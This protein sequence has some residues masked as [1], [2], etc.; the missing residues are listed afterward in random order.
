MRTILALVAVASALVF[1]MVPIPTPYNII[2]MAVLVVCVLMLTREKRVIHIVKQYV[3]VPD[4]KELQ[5]RL[6]SAEEKFHEDKTRPVDVD[7]AQE[8]INRLRKR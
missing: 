4:K 2:P 7:K 1:A 3:P 6:D 8:L 5:E